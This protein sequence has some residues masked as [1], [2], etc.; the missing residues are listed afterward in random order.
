MVTRK[1]EI[2]NPARARV[3]DADHN[4]E[5]E[6]KSQLDYDNKVGDKVL[7]RKDGILHKIESPYHREP[8]TNT[9]VYTNGTIRVTCGTKSERINIRRV[10]SFLENTN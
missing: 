2:T 8:W 7:V 4:T 10:T 1:Q 6:N 3:E 9:S 5:Q